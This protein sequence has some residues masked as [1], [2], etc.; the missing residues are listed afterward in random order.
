LWRLTSISE[1]LGAKR[2]KEARVAKAQILAQIVELDC[3]ADTSGLEDEYWAFRYHLEE[4]LM[5]IF[6][7]E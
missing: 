4:E 6:R 5:N 3:L 7:N 2:G 1:G